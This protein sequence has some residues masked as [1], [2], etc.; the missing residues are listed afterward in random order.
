MAEKTM[1]EKAGE[2]VGFGIAM[3]GCGGSCF[4]LPHHHRDGFVRDTLSYSFTMRDWPTTKVSLRKM[5][6]KGFVQHQH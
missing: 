6:E 5:L 1:V 3:A 2:A 4:A